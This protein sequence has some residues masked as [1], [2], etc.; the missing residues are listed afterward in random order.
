MSYVCLLSNRNVDSSSEDEGLEGNGNDG[1]RLPK[2]ADLSEKEV[3]V[4]DLCLLKLKKCSVTTQGSPQDLMLWMKIIEFQKDLTE[5]YFHWIS[6]RVADDNKYGGVPWNY[7][8]IPIMNCSETLTSVELVNLSM[9]SGNPVDSP[10]GIEPLNL[11]MFKFCRNLKNLTLRCPEN[12]GNP[13]FELVDQFEDEI[14]DNEFENIL[15]INGI[16]LPESVESLEIAYFPMLTGDIEA[17][18]YKC[19]RLRRLFLKDCGKT[20]NLGITAEII[21]QIAKLEHLKFLEIIGFNDSTVDNKR[22]LELVC[23]SIGFPY[24]SDT[25]LEFNNGASTAYES[26]KPIRSLD[27]LAND[28]D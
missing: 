1:H 21:Y 17:I 10:R 3:H 24:D 12:H 19:P 7:F 2:P 5:L 9:I 11:D 15:M 28:S 6:N 18:V 16:D 26:L 22:N 23:L 25:W 4:K 13:Q 27:F 8:R 20:G 14:H